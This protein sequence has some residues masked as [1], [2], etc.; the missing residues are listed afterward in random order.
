[1]RKRNQSK[2]EKNRFFLFQLNWIFFHKLFYKS[3]KYA[4]FSCCRFYYRKY[5]FCPRNWKCNIILS[6]YPWNYA[7]FAFTFQKIC[8]QE[9]QAE[10]LGV[11]K[12][13]NK[14]PACILKYTFWN[15]HALIKNTT[16]SSVGFCPMDLITPRSSL[17]DIDPLPS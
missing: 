8:K 6:K 1:M 4:N 15:R 10:V 17:V 2:L 14:Y 16:S 3:W 5:V 13:E 12:S 7:F 9:F 11:H